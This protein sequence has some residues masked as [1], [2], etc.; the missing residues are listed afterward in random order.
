MEIGDLIKIIQD[1]G[2]IALLGVNTFV[3]WQVYQKCITGR[4]DDLKDDA[5]KPHDK[6]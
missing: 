3:L 2:L 4:I 6:P 1:G 5:G